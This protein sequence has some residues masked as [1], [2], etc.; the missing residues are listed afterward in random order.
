MGN[1]ESYNNNINIPKEL[2]NLKN[3]SHFL[4]TYKKVKNWYGDNFD[5]NEIKIIKWVRT[6]SYN[7]YKKD[8][9][10]TKSIIISNR[11]DKWIFEYRYSYFTNIDKNIIRQI[12]DAN[13]QRAFRDIAITIEEKFHNLSADEIA[14]IQKEFQ[15][16][17]NK[18]K[19]PNA[20]KIAT[21]IADN[22]WASEI[23]TVINA[24]TWSLNE[25]QDIANDIISKLNDTWDNN[26]TNDVDGISLDT[27][28]NNKKQTKKY[29]KWPSKDLLKWMDKITLSPCF[30]DIENKLFKQNQYN[31]NEY[32]NEEYVRY[33]FKESAQHLAKYGVDEI[34]DNT[35]KIICD[36]LKLISS[37]VEHSSTK[38]KQRVLTE[39]FT[40]DK[41]FTILWNALEDINQDINSLIDNTSDKVDEQILKEIENADLEEEISYLEENS[42]SGEWYKKARIVQIKYINKLKN[43]EELSEKEMLLFEKLNLILWEDWKLIWKVIKLRKIRQIQKNNEAKKFDWMIKAPQFEQVEWNIKSINPDNIVKNNQNIHDYVFKKDEDIPSNFYWKIDEEYRK[44]LYQKLIKIHKNDIA[45]V[46]SIRYI[47]DYGHINHKKAKAENIDEKSLQQNLKTINEMID[48]LAK[49]EFHD[50][51]KIKKINEV[52][53][54]KSIMTTC[55]RALSNYFDSTNN[56]WENFADSFE[57][58]DINEDIDFNEETGIIKM[59][60]KIWWDNVIWLYYDTKKWE[61]SFDNFIWYNSNI[62]YVIWTN[63]WEK[64][65]LN[66]KL[67]TMEEME[68]QSNKVDK[69]LIYKLSIN[70][71]FYIKALSKCINESLWLWC[72]QW[73]IGTEMDVN[74]Q[75]VKEF[76]EKNILKQ[77]IFRSIYTKYY[78]QDSI[79]KIINDKLE[80]SEWNDKQQFKLIKLISDSID[81]CKNS[82]ELLRFRNLIVEFD[83][84]ISPNL[85]Y[86]KNDKL[87]KTLFAN[88]LN[89][90][91]DIYDQSASIMENENSNIA[92]NKNN[93]WIYGDIDN[94]AANPSLNYYTFLDLLAE[95]QG[96]N[97]IINLDAFDNVIKTL[98]TD[99][100]QLLDKQDGVLWTNY[101]L[102]VVEWDL[103]EIVPISNQ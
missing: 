32:W 52:C 60:W 76:N 103:A 55:F 96:T 29:Q 73:F 41:W 62:W 82:N 37:W 54:R 35:F 53:T 101:L 49:K 48:E 46:E 26:P 44:I 91:N 43:W 8:I 3:Q 4:D 13:K 23:N 56:N 100:A 65:K 58:W 12:P 7:E 88:N 16:A 63:N 28:N 51:E 6:N 47:D 98:Q 78:D 11:I 19:L 42:I 31:W 67:P 80:I 93:S 9:N 90:D 39:I 69:D 57:I 81:N 70:T 18:W 97:R 79:D 74:K 89:D 75:F 64:E 95:D 20:D 24:S 72:F 2:D 33:F 94:H 34:D 102:K 15:N 50:K 92:V 10:N 99:W 1:F 14:V 85:N 84:V 83:R 25:L 5:D 22:R 68:R 27:Q 71:P 38:L 36:Q 66:I 40:Q 87:L 61:L 86:V 59:K 30:Q 45:F 21:E 77:E 17:K